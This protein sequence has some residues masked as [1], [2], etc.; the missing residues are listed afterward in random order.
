MKISIL[1]K[2]RGPSGDNLHK[3]LGC[4]LGTWRRSLVAAGRLRRRRA[5]EQNPRQEV[6]A[7]HL[8]EGDDLDREDLGHQPVPEEVSGDCG[9]DA[10]DSD[11]DNREKAGADVDCQLLQPVHS[12]SPLKVRFSTALIPQRSGVFQDS[13]NI[14]N[15]AYTGLKVKRTTAQQKSPYFRAFSGF[16]YWIKKFSPPKIKIWFEPMFFSGLFCGFLRCGSADNFKYFF[17]GLASSVRSTHNYSF[18]NKAPG[19]RSPGVAEVF[20]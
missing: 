7:P 2:V 12:F 20:R 16:L 5:L 3:G 17:G 6:D 13:D 18:K 1:E 19:A 15:I 10:H 4:E 9:N 14:A 11:D 8:P